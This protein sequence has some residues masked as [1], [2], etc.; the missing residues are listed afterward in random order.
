MGWTHWVLGFFKGFR[1]TPLSIDVF[2][3]GL[4]RQEA[5]VELVLLETPF[6]YGV[7]IEMISFCG[8][9]YFFPVL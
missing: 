2:F 9:P 7:C 1:N 3:K 8:M 4:P 5:L 6:I